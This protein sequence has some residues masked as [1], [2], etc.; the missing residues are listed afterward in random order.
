MLFWSLISLL[1]LHGHDIPWPEIIHAWS[2]DVH[3][4]LQYC[5]FSSRASV[6]MQDIVKKSHFF[7]P[8]ASSIPYLCLKVKFTP[9]LSLVPWPSFMTLCSPLPLVITGKVSCVNILFSE[10]FK[11]RFINLNGIY[12]FNIS[13]EK[14]IELAIYYRR[15][16][17]IC[18]ILFCVLN[19]LIFKIKISLLFSSSSK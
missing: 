13:Q 8:A 14:T 3:V 11:K 1:V 2:A 7:F 18:F 4:C 19:N 17:M 15:I 9:S 10:D 12:F 5:L 16:L 6:S